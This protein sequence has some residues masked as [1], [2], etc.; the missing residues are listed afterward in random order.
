MKNRYNKLTLILLN[1][2][3]MMFIAK[4][5]SGDLHGIT[6]DIKDIF[7]YYYSHT[8]LGEKITIINILISVFPIIIMVSI[9]ADE[10]SIELEKNATYIFTRSVNRKKWITRKFIHIFI[11]LIKIQLIQFSISFMYFSALGYRINDLKSSLVIIIELFILTTLTQ[12]ILIVIS[13]LVTLKTSNIY[14]YTFCN[15]IFLINILIFHLFYFTKQTLVQY[16]PFTQ[17]ILSIQENILVNRNIRYL[18][19]FIPGYN[20]TEAVIYDIII[21]I[22]LI[23]VGR[24]IIEKHEFY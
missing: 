20:F 16:L 13:S 12:Y 4:I 11:S 15:F 24:K 1:I 3:T 17:Y 5:L 10:V 23:L 2:F 18:S 22:T 21:I 6:L 7:I 19:N 9:F 8:F 14:G